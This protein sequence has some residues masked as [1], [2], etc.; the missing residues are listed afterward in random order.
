MFGNI[1]GFDFNKGERDEG[2]KGG[3]TGVNTS[4]MV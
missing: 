1:V 4:T 3:E 2:C